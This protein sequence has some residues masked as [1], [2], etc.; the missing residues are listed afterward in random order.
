MRWL[1]GACYFTGLLLAGAEGDLFPVV[2]L[3]GVALVAVVCI[4]LLRRGGKS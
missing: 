3:A 4:C 1:M 2:N